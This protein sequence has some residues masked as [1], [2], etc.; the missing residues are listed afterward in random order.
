MS[1]SNC[2]LPPSNQI[3][4]RKVTQIVVRPRIRDRSIEAVTR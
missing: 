1:S 3:P 2:D 4:D